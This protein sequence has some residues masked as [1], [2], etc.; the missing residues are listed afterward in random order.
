MCGVA[1]Q[2]PPMRP[3][4]MLRFL[5]PEL[6]EP[7]AI[8]RY[9]AR[10][11]DERWFSNGG[12]CHAELVS[13]LQARI[14]GDT[15][16]V[17]VAN[18]TLGLVLALR[19][20][21]E[22]RAPAGRRRVL[23][24]SFTFAAT[25]TAVAWCGLEPVFVD[26]DPASWHLDPEAL[27]GAL[28]RFGADV[29]AI[30]PCSTFGSPPPLAVSG[31]WE[32]AGRDAGV[33]VLVDSAAGF[34]G[35]TADGTPLGRQGDAE[36]F[37]FHA[38]KPMAIGEGGLVVTRDAEVGARVQ[39]L[40]NFGFGADGVVSGG[41]GLN[42]KLDEWHAATALAALDQLDRVLAARRSHAEAMRPAL[43]AAGLTLQAGGELGTWQFVPA[44]APS[45]A[46]RDAVVRRAAASRVEVR[47]YFSPPLH[48]MP[49]FA[50]APRSGTLPVTEDLAAR[51]LSLPMAND[52]SP[53]DRERILGVVAGDA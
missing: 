44:L 27:D 18:C 38:T 8:A 35:H 16:C 21:V 6:P 45:A 12:P 19:A 46:A 40:A 24:P 43:A 29:A 31:A 53:E 47:C 32:R 7:T 5:T 2:W 50:G 49:A 37:S 30:V 9:F 36:A 33:P 41:P 51:M 23:L 52:L 10:S 14:G 20:L 22:L 13:R 1:E 48:G 26:V 42:A 39:E 34:G 15:T 28:E 17:P 25:A 11:R 3:P 4:P